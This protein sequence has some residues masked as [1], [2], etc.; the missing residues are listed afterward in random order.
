MAKTT[1]R[2]FEQRKTNS[3]TKAGKSWEITK[4]QNRFGQPYIIFG[5]FISFYIRARRTKALLPD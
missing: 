3:K 1:K 5:R 2:T 4:A